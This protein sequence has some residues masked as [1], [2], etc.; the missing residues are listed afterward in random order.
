MLG[1]IW[2]AVFGVMKKD[3]NFIGLFGLIS[4]VECTP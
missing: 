1:R 3:R 2:L 4:S